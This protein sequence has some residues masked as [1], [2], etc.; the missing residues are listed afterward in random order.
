[1]VV[2]IVYGAYE[3]YEFPDMDEWDAKEDM[4]NNVYEKF[5]EDAYIKIDRIDEWE[6]DGENGTDIDVTV[7][8]DK[9]YDIAARNENDATEQAIEMMQNDID[10]FDID[11]IVHIS[12][13]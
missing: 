10:D 4:E 9:I 1:M 6:E 3:F 5:G 12:C 13:Y 8:V 11:S 7:T 2:E